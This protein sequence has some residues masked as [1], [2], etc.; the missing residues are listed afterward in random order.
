C[1]QEQCNCPPSISQ[2]PCPHTVGGWAQM[3]QKLDAL[4]PGVARAW[5]E[6]FL[7][8]WAADLLRFSR[9]GYR[10]RPRGKASAPL[11]GRVGRPGTAL[12]R[13]DQHCALFHPQD[14]VRLDGVALLGARG[15]RDAGLVDR[16]VP[17]APPDLR[18][19]ARDLARAL[20][21]APWLVGVEA[22]PQA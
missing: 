4:G 12:L 22:A 14:R 17:E 21:Q 7:A 6:R 3:L 2:V 18:R 5:V 8:R 10:Q 16:V 1:C 20:R 19:A 11:L 9:R 13:C 15:K